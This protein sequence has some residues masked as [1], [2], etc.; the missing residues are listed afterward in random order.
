MDNATYETPPTPTPKKPEKIR[1]RRC[2]LRMRIGSTEMPASPGDEGVSVSSDFD[3]DGSIFIP[4]R[5]KGAIGSRY[6]V[7][8]D[9]TSF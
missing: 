1:R 5:P 2:F 8:F 3:S 6:G 4:Y 9:S 7:K